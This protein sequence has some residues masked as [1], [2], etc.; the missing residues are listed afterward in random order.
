[1]TFTLKSHIY[2]SKEKR[3]VEIVIL[4]FSH[5]GKGDLG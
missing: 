4:Y 1:M 5:E 2:L 3:K